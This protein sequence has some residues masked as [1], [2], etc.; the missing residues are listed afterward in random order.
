[1]YSDYFEHFRNIK[2]D[3]EKADGFHLLFRSFLCQAI[4]E[5]FSSEELLI[6]GM[7]LKAVFLF[8]NHL[9]VIIHVV[10]CI[11]LNNL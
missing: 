1:M 5:E 6:P 8:A 2:I 11:K 7:N 3:F 9:S 4:K 10:I